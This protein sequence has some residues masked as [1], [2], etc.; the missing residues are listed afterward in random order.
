MDEETQTQTPQSEQEHQSKF[1]LPEALLVGSFIALV[2]TIDILGLLFAFPTSDV[3]S[4][5]AFPATQIYMY[6]KGVKGNYLL[7]GNL[8]KLIPWIG[9]LPIRTATFIIVV[10]TENHPKLQAVVSVAAVAT[11][12]G[13]VGGAAGGAKAV[14]GEAKAGV[15]AAEGEMKAG[16][17]AGAPGAVGVEEVPAIEGAPTEVGPSAEEQA[18]KV[19]VAPEEVGLPAEEAGAAPEEG[20]PKEEGGAPE[21]AATTP[22]EKEA[23]GEE[24]TPLEKLPQELGLKGEVPPEEEKPTKEGEEEVPHLTWEE[25]HRQQ[26]KKEAGEWLGGLKLKKDIEEAHKRDKEQKK[27]TEGGENKEML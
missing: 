17:A 2:D 20:A 23:I 7:I 10:Y 3:T 15:G 4:I 26:V 22:E 11:G 25:K 8:I 27:K 1:P 24:P 12:A 14:E 18:Q 6:L 19:G 21:R 16:A 5:V 9:D 13:G